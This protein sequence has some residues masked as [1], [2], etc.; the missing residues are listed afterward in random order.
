VIKHDKLL[1][2][3][4]KSLKPSG[5]RR[6]FD[7]AESIEGC[8]SLGVGEPDFVTPWI[9]RQAGIESLEKGRTWYTSNSGLSE[10]REEISRYQL[11][12]YGLNYSA[13][14]EIVVTVGGSEAIDICC[15]A[16]INPGDEVIIP[17]PCFV[18][19][20]AV[21]TLSGAEVVPIA[22]KPEDGFRLNPEDLKKAITK[23]TKL[24]IFPFPNNPTGAVMR[25]EH[26]EEIAEILKGTDIMVMSDEIYSELTYGDEKHISIASISEDMHRRTV[27]ISGF[28]KAFAMT[29]WRIGYT[30]G[31]K[32]VMEQILKIH[33]YAIMCAPTTAQYAAVVAMRDCDD[34]VNEMV[35]EYAMRRRYVVDNLNRIGLKCFEPM[36]AFYVFPSIELTGM[37]SQ[38]FCEKL[39]ERKKV[40][41]VPGDAFGASGEG[42][43]RIAYA[44]S[45][46]KLS[47]A[48]GRI[49]EFVD[50]LKVNG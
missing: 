43:V 31:P 4:V 19:Y 7:I 41:I 27:L 40:A 6:F 11:R 44:Q 42:Y 22:T 47:E 49:E 3:V 48:M 2:D 28:S 37:K 17:T 45:I 21:A 34:V 13:A 20:D 38:E 46:S 32:T 5:I 36:G 35:T 1:S 10:L 26:L 39:L 25:R 18:A 24:L 14:E 33:Q 23:K 12:K 16:L 30:C 29:G 15:R 8:I 9:I 50:E